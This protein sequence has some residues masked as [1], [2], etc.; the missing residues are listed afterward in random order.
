MDKKF[1]VNQAI[2]DNNLDL[3]LKFLNE[4]IHKFGSL[5]PANKVI[6]NMYGECLNAKYYIK[7]LKNKFSD[8][9]K[10]K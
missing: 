7:Y 5:K 3:V 4:N 10:L 8:I 6:H 1:D 2:E 9:Y